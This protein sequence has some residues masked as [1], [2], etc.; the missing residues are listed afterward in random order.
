MLFV[1]V[2]LY[3][4]DKDLCD[5]GKHSSWYATGSDDPRE[6]FKKVTLR[7]ALEL[8]FKAGGPQLNSM[9][10]RAR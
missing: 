10:H 2:R 5:S 4:P 1:D 3:H 6:N 8:Y 9:P 7:P